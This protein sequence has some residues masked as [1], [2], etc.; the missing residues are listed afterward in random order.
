MTIGL[1]G[2]PNA[3]KLEIGDDVNAYFSP[4]S[5]GRSFNDHLRL[6]RTWIAQNNYAVSVCWVMDERYHTVKFITPFLT[7]SEATLLTSPYYLVYYQNSEGVNVPLFAT[8]DYSLILRF[9][10]DYPEL[11]SSIICVS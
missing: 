10:K 9:E 2:D 3:P 1:G 8:S 4:K 5:N 6:M 11:S 7:K